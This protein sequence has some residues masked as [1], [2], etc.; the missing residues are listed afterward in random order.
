MDEHVDVVRRYWTEFELIPNTVFRSKSIEGVRGWSH[1]AGR[2]IRKPLR[3]PIPSMDVGLV[4]RASVEPTP[5]AE[6]A[7]G[8]LRMVL[9]DMARQG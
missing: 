8:V 2:I 7:A 9:K 5:A 4:T 3:E 1:D 6:A